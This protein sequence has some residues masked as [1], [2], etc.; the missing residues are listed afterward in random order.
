MPAAACVR[1]FAVFH[2]DDA[3]PGAAPLCPAC[4]AAHAVSSPAIP[5]PAISPAPAPARRRLLLRLGV[6]AAVLA[7]M[8]ALA[9]VAV[10]AGWFVL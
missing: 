3:R 6:A 1:C 8:A 4:A 9:G 7:A 10:A 5:A 2:T